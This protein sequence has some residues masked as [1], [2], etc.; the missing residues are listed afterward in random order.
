M[1]RHSLKG[2]NGYFDVFLA[3]PRPFETK[4]LPNGRTAEIESLL[5]PL[6]LQPQFKYFDLKNIWININVGVSKKIHFKKG[7]IIIYFEIFSFG[8]FLRAEHFFKNCG[9][10][11]IRGPNETWGWQKVFLKL[12]KVRVSVLSWCTRL[13]TLPFAIF[14]LD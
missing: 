10:Y 5:V 7:A 14:R 6:Q 13:Y 11:C 4:F 8:E 1:L 12:E 3:Q 2:R 9:P